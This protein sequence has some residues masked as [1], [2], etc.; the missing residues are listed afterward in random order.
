MLPLSARNESIARVR[1]AAPGG[2]VPPPWLAAA[3]TKRLARATAPAAMPHHTPLHVR[4]ATGTM[5][6]GWIRSY[7]SVTSCAMS[8][9]PRSVNPVL[10][11]PR[12]PIVSQ[13]LIRSSV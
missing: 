6:C 13:S 10:H 5:L 2:I 3:R 4:C 11:V 7:G 12:I 9:F 1:C 8:P